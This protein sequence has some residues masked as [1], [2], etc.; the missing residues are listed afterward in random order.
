M[1]TL[2]FF[3]G[4]VWEVI[5]YGGSSMGSPTQSTQLAAEK[6]SLTAYRI[7]GRRYLRME[8]A[9]ADREWMD[10]TTQGWANRCLPLK[11]ANQSGWVI[12]NDCEFEAVWGGLP[13]L[14]NLKILAKNE[15][16]VTA[17]SM[18]GHGVVT[19]AIPYLFR[20]PPGYNLYVRGPSNSSKDYA[21]PFDAIVETDW[22]PYPFTMNWRITKPLKTVK[23]EKDEPICLIMPVKRGGL[24]DIVPEIRN[25]ESVPELF[26]GYEKWHRSRVAAQ[27]VAERA[28]KAKKVRT[29]QERA[30]DLAATPKQG[31]YIRGLGHMGEKVDDHQAHGHQ[32]RLALA[33]FTEA[34][35]PSTVADPLP[36]D[37][38]DNRSKS[39]WKRWF[40]R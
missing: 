6:I 40:R 17:V 33:P 37:V 9:P 12:L 21:T 2:L 22:L 29:P 20:T 10:V 26:E 27:E 8:P 1:W 16:R 24:E 7:P 23:F 39:F 4:K 31:H 14:D 36:T 28:A 5:F 34:E 35:P 19:W 11:I 3:S 15:K 25:L 13:G 30:A 38:P 32:T 18:F